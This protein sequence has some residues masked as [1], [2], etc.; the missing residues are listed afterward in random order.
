M[1]PLRLQEHRS[2]YARESPFSARFEGILSLLRQFARRKSVGTEISGAC[3]R[4]AGRF[5]AVWLRLTVLT[6]RVH[7]FRACGRQTGSCLRLELVRNLV[8]WC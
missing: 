5:A 4:E 1:A 2:S 3:S 6:R 8:N 7:S